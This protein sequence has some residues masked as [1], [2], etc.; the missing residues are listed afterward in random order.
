[1]TDPDLPRFDPEQAVLGA[2]QAALCS[3]HYAGLMRA[4]GLDPA[5]IRSL[6]SFTRLVPVLRK[7]QWF[8]PAVPFERLCRDG[9]LG[10]VR[11]LMVSS[12]FSG[13]NSFAVA[14]AEELAATAA[15]IDAALDL[16]FGTD[17]TPTLLI[18]AFPM[19]I[20]LPTRHP[21]AETGPRSDLVLRILARFGPCY[22]QTVILADPHFLKKIVDEGNEAALDWQARNVSFVAG[23][24]WLPQTLR[25]YL[26]AQTGIADDSARVL[27]GTMGLTELGLNLFFETRETVRLRRLAAADPLLRE[28]L[29]PGQGPAVPSLFHYDPTRFHIESIAH[30]AGRELVVTCLSGARRVPMIRYAGGDLGDTLYPRQLMETLHALGR[31]AL[32]P[33]LPL[34]CGW[35]AGRA[36]ALHTAAGT[37][38]AEALRHGLYRDP[39]VAAAVTGHFSIHTTSATE[40]AA[41]QLRRGR[42]ASSAL[43]T[44]T[45]EALFSLVA[46]PLPTDLYGYDEYPFG[47][48]LD[49]QS[50]FRHGC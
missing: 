49:Y 10:S 29:F 13:N 2:F 50:K 9:E 30:P 1:M 3:P 40:R 14:T 48:D 34:P 28:A 37:L 15:G 31:P 11:S 7:E 38:R 35:V 46:T 42:S 43:R 26:H 39:V 45:R 32:A 22:E 27:L 24:D 19:G 44:A 6:A 47:K 36:P 20:H 25:A 8:N 16:L 17:R 4:A 18:N 33:T 5:A 23:Q 21:L 12:G 41:V